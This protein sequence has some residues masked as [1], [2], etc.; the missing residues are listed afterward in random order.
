MTKWSRRRLQAR[1]NRVDLSPLLTFEDV[2]PKG[3][4]SGSS[5]CLPIADAPPLR[6]RLWPCVTM[7]TGAHDP[8]SDRSASIRRRSKRQFGTMLRLRETVGIARS[9]GDNGH[10]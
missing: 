3:S 7:A 10:E 8:R 6:I 9:G 5:G 1:T 4:M 2:G